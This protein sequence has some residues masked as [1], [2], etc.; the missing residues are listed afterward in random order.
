ML[1]FK[2]KTELAIQPNM[3]HLG[4]DTFNLAP[5]ISEREAVERNIS[6]QPASWMNGEIQS[7]P[8]TK[9][10]GINRPIRIPDCS[11]AALY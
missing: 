2:D 4:K 6:S 8:E 9:A 1:P 7:R 5:G 3:L 11:D 10:G